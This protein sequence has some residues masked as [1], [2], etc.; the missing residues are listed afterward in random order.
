[1]HK[2][3]G[4]QCSD[5]ES[6]PSLTV[7]CRA[8]HH[9]SG[10]APLFGQPETTEQEET[11]EDE[12]VTTST[13]KHKDNYERGALPEALRVSNRWEEDGSSLTAVLDI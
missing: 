9:R 3:L 10:V 4:D 7:A 13:V 1:M 2:Y 5:I 8:Q 12:R 6:L 11:S